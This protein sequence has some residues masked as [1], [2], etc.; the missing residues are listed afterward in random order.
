M[1]SATDE[2]VAALF[3]NLDTDGNGEID[4]EEWWTWY[5]GVLEAMDEKKKVGGVWHGVLCDTTIK[6]STQRRAHAHTD[7]P[8]HGHTDTRTH[9]H[10]DKLT[11]R[12]TETPTHRRT[13][14]PTH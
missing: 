1:A 5:G 11:R 4:Y 3:N 14:T 12:H 2:E 13:D 8:T 10:T 7:T 6:P 9:R